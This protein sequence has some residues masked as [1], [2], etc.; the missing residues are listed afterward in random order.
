MNDFGHLLAKQLHKPHWLP[1]PS[2]ALKLLLGEMSMLV[3]E[4]QHVLPKK[5]IDHG[6]QFSYS[7]L[8]EALENLEI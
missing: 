8:N 7:N 1:V 2:F 3:L 6:F 5:A 4:G